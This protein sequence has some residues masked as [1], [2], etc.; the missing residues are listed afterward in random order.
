MVEQCFWTLLPS[1]E[2]VAVGNQLDEAEVEVVA[3]EEEGLVAEG[4]EEEVDY[5]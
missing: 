5:I 3:E 4:A 1:K 2:V